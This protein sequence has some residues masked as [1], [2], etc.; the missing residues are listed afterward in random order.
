MY[1][2]A[3]G[4]IPGDLA[5]LGRLSVQPDVHIRNLSISCRDRKGKINNKIDE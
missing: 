3:Q 5:T 4:F 2:A 1:A